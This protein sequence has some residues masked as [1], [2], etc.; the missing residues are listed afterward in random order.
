MD[1]RNGYILSDVSELFVAKSLSMETTQLSTSFRSKRLVITKEGNYL[2][3]LQLLRFTRDVFFVNLVLLGGDVLQNPGRVRIQCFNCHKT[4][5]KNQGRADCSV[6]LQSY[7]LKCLGVDFESSKKCSL[8]SVSGMEFGGESGVEYTDFNTATELNEAI[9]LQGMK[10]IHQNIRS[11][12]GKLDELNI[13][14]SQCLNLHILAFTE[15]W[16]DNGITDGEISLP[17]Y[18]IFRSDR[19]NGKGG[20]IAVYVKEFLSIIRRVDLEQQ[21][22]GECILLEILLPKA[23]GILFGTFYRP[24]S[25]TDFMNP[26]RDV[27]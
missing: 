1:K 19:P 15:T 14:I 22:P 23:N 9:I 26:F 10:F 11:I 12:R 20:G 6:C 16:L 5:R 18:K 8:C 27:L 7:H 17:G 24:P 21:F 25:Q 13:L 3:C 4:I 2:Q